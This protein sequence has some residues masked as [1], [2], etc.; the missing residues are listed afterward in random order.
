MASHDPRRVSLTTP[1]QQRAAAAREA[2]DLRD[3]ILDLLLEHVLDGDRREELVELRQWLSEVEER[4]GSR[5]VPA[6]GDTMWR[7]PK[8][9]PACGAPLAE[10]RRAGSRPS[11]NLRPAE[12]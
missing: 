6:E 3:Q 4:A 9:L 12:P 1:E 11:L 8:G 2:R 7:L 10:R 5:R